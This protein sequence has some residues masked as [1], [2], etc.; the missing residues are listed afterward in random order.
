[1]IERG[2]TREQR[3]A[4]QAALDLKNKR[5]GL[6]IFQA[7]WIMV[8]VCLSLVAISLRNSSPTWPQNVERLIPTLVTLALLGSSWLVRTATRA[9]KADVS[10]VFA[11]QWR[12]ALGLGLIFIVVMAVEWVT[13]PD[14]GGQYRS[15]FRMMV[16]YHIVHALAIGAFMLKVY[17]NRHSYHAAHFWPVEGAAGLWH[18]VVVAWVLFFAVLYLI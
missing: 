10:E 4:A 18:F 16:G 11:G 6:A 15:V 17:Q 1:M 3:A 9:V 8:F 12:L 13:A 7:S 5:T 14:V 2:L